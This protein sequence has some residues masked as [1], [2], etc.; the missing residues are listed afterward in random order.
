[1]AYCS[2]Q[3]RNTYQERGTTDTRR[4]HIRNRVNMQLNI[5][6]AIDLRRAPAVTLSAEPLND[7]VACGFRLVLFEPT[8][9]FMHGTLSLVYAA[10]Q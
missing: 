2:R 7:L 3:R 1:M 8:G 5:L 9:T 6:L 4:A 10:R